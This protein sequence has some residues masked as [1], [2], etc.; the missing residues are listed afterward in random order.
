MPNRDR[1]VPG[2]AIL[3]EEQAYWLYSVRC[4][5]DVAARVI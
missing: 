4:C 1:Y 5:F 2:V 3:A